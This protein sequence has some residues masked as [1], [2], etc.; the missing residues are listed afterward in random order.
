MATH[1]VIC[2]KESCGWMATRAARTGR[3]MRCGSSILW[4]AGKR[5]MQE[6]YQT[7]ALASELA[8]FKN[9]QIKA[10]L[11]AAAKRQARSPT[12]APPIERGS[13]YVPIDRYDTSA[14]PRESAFPG[15]RVPVE[16]KM[17]TLDTGRVTTFRCPP[18]PKKKL[19]GRARRRFIAT[20]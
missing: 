19:L 11:R 3:C 18:K 1:K 13:G 7:C 2:S 15:G 14:R 6:M 4:A 5:P 20:R 10:K 8:Q 9:D 12:P 16:M 17:R